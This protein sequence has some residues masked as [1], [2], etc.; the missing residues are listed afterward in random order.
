M[1]EVWK[2]LFLRE[3]RIRDLFEPVDGT[4]QYYCRPAKHGKT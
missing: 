1:G 4:K 2:E 3:E